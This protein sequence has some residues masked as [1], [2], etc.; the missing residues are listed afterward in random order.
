MVGFDTRAVRDA[1]SAGRPRGAPMSAVTTITDPDRLAI[2]TVRT[3]CI[4]AVQQ[5]ASAAG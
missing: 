1:Q 2:T 3:L 5:A 4:D